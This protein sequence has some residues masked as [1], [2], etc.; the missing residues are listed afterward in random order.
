MSPDFWIFRA[1]QRIPILLL[2]MRNNMKGKR[3]LDVPETDDQNGYA[4]NQ[5]LSDYQKL[6]MMLSNLHFYDMS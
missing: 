4:R 1:N 2:I 3:E 5:R 6:K